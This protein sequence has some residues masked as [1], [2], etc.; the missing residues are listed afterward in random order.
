MS[1]S[2]FSI[3]L[4]LEPAAA[5]LMGLAILGQRLGPVEVLA[6][7]LVVIASAGANWRTS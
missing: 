6:I 7:T 3:L 4:S 2:T 5:A 1:A